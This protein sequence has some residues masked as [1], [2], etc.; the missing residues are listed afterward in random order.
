VARQ[1]KY[2]EGGGQ[3]GLLPFFPLALAVVGVLNLV[4]A[5]HRFHLLMGIGCFAA[6]ASLVLGF[7]RRSP[8]RSFDAARAPF[9]A[10]LFVWAV[11]LYGY[12][13]LSAAGDALDRV[14][15]G[16]LGSLYVFVLADRVLTLP[17][18]FAGDGPGAG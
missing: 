4:A 18:R 11:G 16:L 3:A 5:D 14:T 1:Q 12:G 2:D 13:T 17:H 8:A 9:A 7:W 6:A 10:L 15:A